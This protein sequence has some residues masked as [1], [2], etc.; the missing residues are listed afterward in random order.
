MTTTFCRDSDLE[1]IA[2]ELPTS[3]RARWNSARKAAVVQAVDAGMLSKNK[4]LERYRLS[5]SEFRSWQIS[6]AAAGQDGLKIRELQA[7]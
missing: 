2:K 5:H 3:Y 7:H 6:F 4:A 1:A